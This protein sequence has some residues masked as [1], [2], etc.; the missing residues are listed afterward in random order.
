M[1]EI[2]NNTLEEDHQVD[3]LNEELRIIIS[4]PK[5]EEQ[6]E[7]ALKDDVTIILFEGALKDLMEEV[8]M[9]SLPKIFQERIKYLWYFILCSHVPKKHINGYLLI[10]AYSQSIL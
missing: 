5:Y 1:Q 4:E 6:F 9:E 8:Q 10:F 7:G 3:M 2:S